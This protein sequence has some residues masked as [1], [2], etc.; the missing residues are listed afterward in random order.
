[1]QGI[2]ET[3]RERE[4]I[5]KHS[6][7]IK[8]TAK[9]ESEEKE[10]QKI[11]DKE[12][13]KQVKK[14]KKK[15]WKKNGAPLSSTALCGVSWFCTSHPLRSR[16]FNTTPPTFSGALFREGN[17]TYIHNIFMSKVFFFLIFWVTF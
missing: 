9:Q 8:E 7:T 1:M 2:V 17:E 11:V 14:E 4:N 13:H 12:K 6:N 15:W 10:R 5:P 3:E 16:E